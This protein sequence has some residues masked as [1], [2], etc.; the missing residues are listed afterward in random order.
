MVYVLDADGRPLMPTRRHGKV[1]HL[2]REGKAKVTNRRPFTIQLLYESTAYVQ[3]L[4]GGTDPGRTNI[5]N[6]V[7]FCNG[8]TISVLYAD[9]VTSRNKEVPKFMQKRAEHRRGSRRGERKRRQRRAVQN[10]QSFGVRERILP[11]C[12]EPIVLHDIRNTEAKFNNRKREPG[13][14]T[15]T[16]RQ[17]VQ[18]HRNQI[19]YICSILPVTD[20]TLELN[21]FSFMELEN[22]RIFGTDFQNGRMKGYDSV[23]KYVSA[24][25]DGVC[26]F[27][28]ERIEHYHHIL[29]RSK[30]GSNRPENIAGLCKYHHK[31]IHK[32][33]KWTEKL[34]RIGEKKTYAALSVLNQAIPYIYRELLG[35]FGEEH[36][37]LTT[38]YQTKEKRE[39]S[40]LSKDHVYDAVA[41]AAT[42]FHE[43]YGIVS[44]LPEIYEVRQYRR[45]DRAH[46]KAQTERT[47]KLDGKVVAKNRR[48]RMEQK[49]PSLHEF[50]L[51][52]KR[53]HGKREAK[54][55][56]GQLT[57]QK[58]IRRYN[59]SD[60]L[61]PGTEFY[62]NGNRLIMSGQLT[63]GTYLRAFGDTKTNY[64]KKKVMIARKNKGLVYL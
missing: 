58:S 24:L 13:W 26:I 46:I 49:E 9:H 53:L 22:G 1:R 64:P 56:M 39:R 50:Y 19:R 21:R 57:V 6:A 54:R 16:V 33:R 12:K 3:N 32:D 8:D 27:C 59:A 7:V 55:V 15:P 36:V 62:Y 35:I 14:I 48:K 45:H 43:S 51:E 28:G 38:G 63:N 60:R 29:P 40:G 37:H 20:W 31:L 61:M 23:E 47:Y 30:G 17:L 34:N 2:L 4:S 18:T 52:Q 41:I 42:S 11:G 25:Q 10:R 44:Y 5:G